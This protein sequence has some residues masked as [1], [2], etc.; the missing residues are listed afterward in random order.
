[1]DSLDGW[2]PE[3]P[4]G[5]VLPT[6]LKPSSSLNGLVIRPESLL[7]QVFEPAYLRTACANF[8][9]QSERYEEKLDKFFLS[10]DSRFSM[11][12]ECVARATY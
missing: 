9:E 5:V 3:K 8:P 6:S 10:L 1:M 12:C 7:R 4:P 11:S 2:E